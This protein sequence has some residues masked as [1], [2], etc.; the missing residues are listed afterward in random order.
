MS[1]N[2]NTPTPHNAA[3]Y[4]EIAPTVIMPGDPLRAKFI[5]ETWLEDAKE[6]NT[7]RGMFGY[8]GS[9]RGEK[10]SVQGHGMGI[11]SIGIYTYE[12]YNFYGV[13]RI[14]RVGS[15]GAIQEGIALGVLVIAMSASTDSAYVSQADLPGTLSLVASYPLLEQAVTL[16][17]EN[18][19]PFHAGN[20]L[21]SD[22]FY[23]E[24]TKVLKKW[25]S[26]GVLA[27]EMESAGLYYN[28]IKAKKQALCITTVSD[29]PLRGEGA[30]ADER[31]FGF[32]TMIELALELL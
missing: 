11:P 1:S 18:Q 10:V 12:L 3:N 21:S 4:G 26:M 19:L 14:I 27:V 16:A 6:Y 17:R 15:S 24:S 31:Q 7:V 8:T 9:Y 2:R 22:V 13:E 28:A 23:N 32:R 5:A 20:V 25:A 30:S 29:L